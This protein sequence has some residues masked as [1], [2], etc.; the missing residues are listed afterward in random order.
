MAVDNTFD[1]RA[2]LKLTAMTAAATLAT[3]CGAPAAP[4]A[5]TSAEPAAGEAASQAAPA[6]PAGPPSSYSEAPMLAERV[7]AGELPPVAERLPPNPEVITPIEE[8]GQYG[9]TMNV[10]IGNPNALFG[11]PQAVLGTELILRIDSDFSSIIG[12][13]AESWE[14][15]ADATEQILHLRQ[16]LKWSDGAP[17]TADDFIFAWDDL[18][19]NE[20][21]SPSGPPSAWRTGSGADSVPL[22]MEKIDDY[23]LRLTF[24]KP[25]PLI[26]LQE[27]FYSG[28]QGGIWQP[29]HYAQ[30]FHTDYADAAELDKMVSDAGFDDWTQLLRDKT[31][32]GSTIP[33]QVGLPGM[34]A[35]IRV[36]D[37]P[38]HHTYERNPYYWKVDTVGNQLPYI[39]RAVI[40]IIDN[41]E[42]AN[43]KLIAGELD[44][45]GRQADLANMELYQANME[46]ASLKLKMWKSTFPGRAVVVPN[47]THKDPQIR[48][49]F[50]NKDVRHA[51]SLAINREEINDVIYFGL[52]EPRQWA[53]W[54]D[55]KYYQEGDTEHW[56]QFDPEQANQLLDAAGYAEK[57]GDGFRL[58]PDGTRVSW[59]IQMDTEQADILSV[60]E[61]LA[62]QWRAV[63]LDPSIRPIN[64][65]LL[66]EM[67]DANDIGM[68][69][70]E[71]DISDI[72]W[73]WE[74][75]IN[76]PGHGNVKWGYAWNLWLN[77]DT[78]NELAQEPP[79]E[80]AWVYNRWQD[81]IDAVSEEEHIAI[82]RE[83][84]EW[85]Y[86]Y[87]PGFG[88]LGIPKPVLMK[89]N[90]TNFPDD[91]V[92]GFSVIRAVPVHP[93]Q[94]FF[95]QS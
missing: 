81:M 11:D 21:F 89:Q 22:T 76:H 45:A 59:V 31:R 42:V 8:V 41:R 4:A 92:W 33:A 39:D 36:E 87:L 32:V 79:E 68:S 95:K 94:F 43:A 38:D 72:T 48:D 88:T 18:M 60:F 56:A 3:A 20:A 6:A 27:C 28:S 34:T 64:R 53:G 14:F 35:F 19:L 62:E 24:A 5:P 29:K 67:V 15:N 70:W 78:E 65:T 71:G 66:T 57:D 17:F 16:G 77:G 61:L 37:A 12:G 90:L 50:Q 51:L 69:G 30:Q 63:G 40:F 91:G 52:G 86:D 54:P 74:S 2:F 85:F 84:W 75:R 10:A 55:S 13:L 49:F 83:L 93:E 58:F 1:R 25:Y 73:V 47:L 23:T 80:V 9:G 7:A 26:V 44:F 82:A 46:S